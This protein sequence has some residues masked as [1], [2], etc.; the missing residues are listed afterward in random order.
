VDAFG[1]LGRL[2]SVPTGYTLY[3]AW[4]TIA[5]NDCAGGQAWYVEYDQS[6]PANGMNI[7]ISV[8]PTA[9]DARPEAAVA[10]AV[11]G[12]PAWL[13]N[14]DATYG[15]VVWQAG[16]LDFQVSGPTAGDS[17]DALVAIANALTA[18][19]ADDPRIVAPADCQ[20]PPGSTCPSDPP[21]G[22]SAPSPT[23]TPT[24]TPTR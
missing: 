22:S 15:F 21:S 18:V 14:K 2:P 17:G 13:L 6:S 9:T 20:V 11:Q 24:P 7:S 23:P 12:H 16:G 4:G 10:T 19:P 1:L 5:R 8:H 3:G